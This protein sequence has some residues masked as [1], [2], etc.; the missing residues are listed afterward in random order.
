MVAPDT[1]WEIA[2]P[3]WE[4]YW[5]RLGRQR[6]HHEPALDLPWK[7]DRLP[8]GSLI[9]HPPSSLRRKDGFEVEGLDFAE[10]EV[11]WSRYSLRHQPRGRQIHRP[12]SFG[13][14]RISR[15]SAKSPRL[16]YPA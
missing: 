13:S 16:V 5:P 12:L 7:P 11:E 4:T 10:I 6:L 9:D 2:R 8:D 15:S 3:S 1:L 14:G